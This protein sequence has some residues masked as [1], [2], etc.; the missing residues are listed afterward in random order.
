MSPR[1]TAVMVSKFCTSSFHKNAG[2]YAAYHHPET[3][4]GAKQ[5]ILRYQLN[6]RDAY[7]KDE[8]QLHSPARELVKVRA[9]QK[10]RH[11]GDYQ[12]ID[13][14]RR[15]Y[16]PMWW[17]GGGSEQKNYMGTLME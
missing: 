3:L 7:G 10:H 14:Y 4:N 12:A 17:S 5:H 16:S 2:L 8:D 15:D 13:D 11:H 1:D 9:A 6:R